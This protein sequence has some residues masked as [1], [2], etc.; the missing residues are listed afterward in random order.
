MCEL[1]NLKKKTKWYYEDEVY[2]ILDCLTCKIPMVVSKSHDFKV[3][4]ETVHH[5]VLFGIVKGVFGG[6]R[7]TF[8]RTQ[9]KVKNHFHWHIVFTGG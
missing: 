5:A 4:I 9:R 7:F 2:I 8:R 3:D 6:K 1:C